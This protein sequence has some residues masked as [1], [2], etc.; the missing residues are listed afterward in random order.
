MKNLEGSPSTIRVQADAP[1]DAID[2][3]MYGQNIEHMGRQ[4]LGGLVAE[5][6][7]AAPQDERGF[8]RD[9]RESI[10]DLRPA[11][12]RWPGGCFAD[13]YHWK[14]GIGAHRPTVANRM[15]GRFLIGRIFGNP[16][17]PLGPLEDNRFGTDEFMA[18]C[19]AAGAEPSLTASLGAD[20]PQEAADWVAYV[21]EHPGA[22]A[23]PTWS[24]GNEQWNI[25][26]PNGCANRPRKYVDRFLRFAEAMRAADPR[27]G[28]VASGGDAFTL[29]RWNEEVIRGIGSAM[30]LLSMHL[31]LPAWVPLRSHVGDSPGAYRA[32]AASG[33]FLEE[34]ILRVE[35][36]AE[37]LV[38][39]TLPIA[40][41][42]WNIL[43]PLRRFTDPY[44][45]LR[46]AIGIAGILHAFHRQARHVKT[47]AMFAMISSAAPPILTTRD[48]LVRTPV[49]HVLRMYRR[50]TGAARLP[51]ETRCPTV[52]VPALLNLPP[53]KAVPV[54]DVSATGDGARVTLFVV[55]RDAVQ[56]LAARVDVAGVRAPGRARVHRIAAGGCSAENTLNDPQAVTERAGEIDWK[57]SLSFP[58]CSVTAVV[59]QP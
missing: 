9:V 33:L 1:L 26:E 14:D 31:Y 15:W 18:L 10:L 2:P 8:R 29:P 7:S 54:L 5:P 59:L 37:R 49:H 16:P 40:F 42:E 25:I 23:V 41:D 22:G 19:R 20:D 45:S 4:V 57:G 6:G 46:E 32:I 39:R 35:E 44:R 48:T 36:T 43:G 21:R 27:I 12:L 38:G 30:D 50:L 17:F 55:N 56:P 58:P 47:A 3:R 13:S 34:Q 28:L 24:V 52:D 11:L 51:A 53:R